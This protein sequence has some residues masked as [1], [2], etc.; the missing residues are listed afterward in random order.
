ML[1][2]GLCWQTPVKTLHPAWRL[3]GAS[4][5]RK[6]EKA[7]QKCSPDYICKERNTVILE[8]TKM[9]NTTR[10]KR[11]LKVMNTFQFRV[12]LKRFHVESLYLITPK[13]KKPS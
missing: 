9:S 5:G 1:P 13:H 2:L 11:S 8:T 4:C 12:I 7:K 6:K 10:V 3:V